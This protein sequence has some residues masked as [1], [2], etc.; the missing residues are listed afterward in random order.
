MWEGK[1]DLDVGGL[2]AQL[3]QY[4][5]NIDNWQVKKEK[6]KQEVFTLL[7]MNTRNNGFKS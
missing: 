5:V 4:R 6:Y 1:R 3:I 2:N 7:D